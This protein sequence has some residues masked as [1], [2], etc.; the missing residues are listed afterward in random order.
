VRRRTS[1]VVVVAILAFLSY[2]RP[3]NAEEP[4]SADDAQNSNVLFIMLDQ[5][6]YDAVGYVQ[7]GMARYR[8]KIT[9]RTPNIDQLASRG[10]S[11][12]TAYAQS[13]SCAPARA[14][15]KTGCTVARHGLIGNKLIE[16]EVYNLMESFRSRITQLT[17]FEGVLSDQRG[18]NVETFGK[19]HFPDMYYG[20]IRHNDYNYQT[21]EFEFHPDQVFKP[22]YQ[23][24]L[25]TMASQIGRIVWNRGDQYNSFNDMYPYTPLP[26][27]PRYKMRTRTSESVLPAWLRGE[28]LGID[29]LSPNY[30]SSAI[31]A[32]MAYRAL[33]R[34]MTAQRNATTNSSSDVTATPFLLSV[35][36]NA[37]V[38]G[39]VHGMWTANA[40]Q[41]CLTP[42]M[43]LGRP[44]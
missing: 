31:V 17:T 28:E 11:F 6:R 14:T 39:C 43:L 22:F 37:P 12:A 35:Q 38:R 41:E 30:T 21:Q 23:A 24:A 2:A 19:W 33:D 8:S 10:V 36:F 27:D 3:L 16:P 40:S 42:F 9:V 15:I 7:R 18:Y 13:A 32:D 44:A 5:L 1:L 29:A 25:R 34:L 20:P 26:T 4:V